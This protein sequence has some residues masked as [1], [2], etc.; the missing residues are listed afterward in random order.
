MNCALEPTTRNLAP[1][2]VSR[3]ACWWYLALHPYTV[4]VALSTVFLS[5]FAA[6]LAAAATALAGI[7]GSLAAIVRSRLVRRALAGEIERSVRS[8]RAALR[9]SRLEKLGCGRRAELAELHSLVED[10]HRAGQAESAAADELEDLLDLFVD[11][12]IAHERLTAALGARPPVLAASADRPG[13]LHAD[14]VRRRAEHRDRC[15]QRAAAIDGELDS[16]VEFVKL[17]A[18]RAACQADAST[19][20][21]VAEIE[22][23]LWDM[24]ARDQAF[25]ALPPAGE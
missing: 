25:A 16:I 20:A 17:A 18:E 12:T 2:P 1:V 5:G 13:A 9:E 4:V 10:I 21:G 6:G 7:L 14:L 15:R 19:G 23:R 24:D 3:L 8:R 11:R 22:R